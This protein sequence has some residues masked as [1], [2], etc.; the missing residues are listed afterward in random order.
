MNRPHRLI[1]AAVLAV[2]APLAQAH[3]GHELHASF[4]EGVMHPFTGWDHLTV[5]LCLGLLAA[6]RG[7]RLAVQAGALLAA[8][9]AG[10]AALGLA[11]PQAT[12]VEPA[13]LATV[14]V[15]TALLLLRSRIGR[16]GLLSLCLAFTLVHGM[17]HGQEAPDGN[18]A[19]Y[20]AGFTLAGTALFALGVLLAQ[21]AFR[22][23]I[24]RL[25]AQTSAGAPSHPVRARPPRG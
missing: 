24:S 3:P 13:I 23:P 10:G 4:L 16:S 19:P 11:F 2:I 18:L 17:A 12:F 1:F 25:R 14:L 5:L 8:S 20:F 9:L 22:A 21:A 15:S 6:G 7:A